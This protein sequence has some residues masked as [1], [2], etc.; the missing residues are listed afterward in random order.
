MVKQVKLKWQEYELETITRIN[1]NTYVLRL[2]K[3]VSDLEPTIT[4]IFG[5]KL[6]IINGHYNKRGYCVGYSLHFEDNP[7]I[8]V[9]DFYLVLDY[10]AKEKDPKNPVFPE[11]ATKDPKICLVKFGDLRETRMYSFIYRKKRNG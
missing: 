10:V 7:A 8:L 1:A 11:L 9:S 6:L 5:D 4:K 3:T 2:A